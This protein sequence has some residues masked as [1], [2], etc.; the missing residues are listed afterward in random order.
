METNAKDLYSCH[1]FLIPF[2]TFFMDRELSTVQ[3]KNRVS[4]VARKGERKTRLFVYPFEIFLC[5]SVDK[6][7]FSLFDENRNTDA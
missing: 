6:D 2:H 1:T 3:K 7:L 5:L 4:L